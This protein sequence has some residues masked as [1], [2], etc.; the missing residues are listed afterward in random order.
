MSELPP[1]SRAADCRT[2][3]RVAITA[4]PGSN[5]GLL[6][7]TTLGAA[8]AVDLGVTKG[9]AYFSFQAVGGTASIRFRSDNAATSTAANSYAVAD[10][11]TVEFWITPYDRYLDCFGT[12]GTV[13]WWQSSPN[14]GGRP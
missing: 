6:S 12:A 9:G 13:R 8:Q 11:T 4:L 7:S 10:G 2:P 3:P 5:F 14:D 1:A